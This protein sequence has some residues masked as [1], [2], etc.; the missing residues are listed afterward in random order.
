M[1]D[2][3]QPSYMSFTVS[4]DTDLDDKSTR[5]S[6][7]S[8]AASA[9][10]KAMDHYIKNDTKTKWVYIGSQ[11]TSSPGN[12]NNF[13]QRTKDDTYYTDLRLK[14]FDKQ[15][16]F[17]KMSAEELRAALGDPVNMQKFAEKAYAEFLADKAVADA[18]R[19]KGMQPPA[20]DPRNP[21]KADVDALSDEQKA[22]REAAAKEALKE[23][24]QKAAEVIQTI[25][26]ARSVKFK[27]QC[28]LLAKIFQ[29][30][31]YKIE[32]IESEKGGEQKPL[33]YLSG[34]GNAC[35]M[36]H[37]DPF[38]FINRMAVYNSQKE[39]LQLPTQEISNL[40]PK[41]RL[42]KVVENDRGDEMEQ[43][44]RFAGNAGEDLEN[45][46]KS[47]DKRGFG[48]GIES[49][50]LTFEGGDP[51]AAK[52]M[53]KGRLVLHANSFD[54][55]LKIRG[56]GR[57]SVPYSYAD[58]ALKTG[59]TGY[60][61]I[62]QKIN[63][64]AHGQNIGDPY[65]LDFRLKAVVGYATPSSFVGDSFSDAI[66]NSFF[67]VNLIP[68]THE[69]KFQEDGTMKFIINYQAYTET[70]F[71]QSGFSVF[72]GDKKTNTNIMGRK[73]KLQ[74]LNETCDAKAVAKFKKEE[75]N[76]VKTDRRSV[77]S[78]IV[79]NLFS[80]QKIR[81]IQL[82]PSQLKKF[83]TEGPFYELKN[84]KLK[85]G[86]LPSSET[87]K[88][89]V[90]KDNN[91]K[92]KDD[93]NKKVRKKASNPSGNYISFFYLSDLV[94]IVLKGMESKLANYSEIVQ[95]AAKGNKVN[96]Y[97]MH[98]ELVRGEKYYNEFRKLRLVLGPI[99][100]VNPSDPSETIVVSLGDL[101]VSIKYFTAWLAS[102][103]VEKDR[104][105][106]NLSSFMKKLVT[107][108]LNSFIND[109]SCFSSTAK[110]S[111]KLRE[112]VFTAYNNDPDFPSDTVTQL[113][114]ELR[115]AKPANPYISRL[116]TEVGNAAGMRPILNVGGAE[117]SPIYG[118][119][120]DEV[121]YLIF[122]ASRTKPMGLLTGIY[123]DDLSMGV[124]HYTIG[125]DRGIV[126]TIQLDRDTRVSA[127]EARF[128][129]EGY[130]GLQQLREIYHANVECYANPHI[131]PGEYIFIDPKGWVPYLDP[132]I[133]ERLNVSNLTDFGIGGYYM[134]VNA[135][136]SYGIANATTK[137]RA[138]WVAQI[139][140]DSE[141]PQ[142]RLTSPQKKKAAA[143]KCAIAGGK[144]KDDKLA[145]K[146]EPSEVSAGRLAGLAF[147]QD[148]MIGDSETAPPP[149]G[150]PEAG[151]N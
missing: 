33:P 101:P 137:F 57:G 1:P 55:I 92:E 108:L 59:G 111:V 127:K 109:D 56:T 48:T 94:D 105:D 82:P 110:Q 42:F 90:K 61:N 99:E 16:A 69:F 28:F 77:I 151:I 79:G 142:K 126:K 17:Y 3:D 6:T 31:R 124:H 58:L 114:S 22:A 52:R 49:F 113:I 12:M 81:F 102:E 138:V 23:G 38:A 119:L 146:E 123:E 136:H 117:N 125:S 4:K 30:V 27:E 93:N 66:N 51:F 87:T 26:K 140:R 97:L 13:M 5:S 75:L 91:K 67:T 84:E 116:F 41:I 130:D 149:S 95:V 46:L 21:A 147:V 132:E 44:Y 89:D 14:M 71:N 10:Q 37:S 122:Y 40:Q 112:T 106:F 100:I 15:N 80:E 18:F 148:L 128:E 96:P 36:V 62:K 43:E 73:L 9:Y 68:T 107:K 29:L 70:F 54:E 150:N 88:D 143:A 8:A 139:T 83:N 32:D 19:E 63:V 60:K 133:S 50:D 25:P 86:T 115:N 134:V 145:K 35:L 135:E 45:L 47:K 103:T 20:T 131:Y 76:A 78:S 65:S 53:I 85:I 129:Q 104:R 120:K 64:H 74:D 39:L 34:N 72:T 11:D 118:D 98:N 2:P 121:N 144:A 141:E 7:A 24:Q